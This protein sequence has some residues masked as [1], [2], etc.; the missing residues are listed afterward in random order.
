MLKGM[1]N[2]EDMILRVEDVTSADGFDKVQTYV[3]FDLKNK[4]RK[5]EIDESRDEPPVPLSDAEVRMV[6]TFT[7]KNAARHESYITNE[8]PDSIYERWKSAFL[9][10]HNM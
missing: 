9:A 10:F 7:L 1:Y 8:H 4:T 2:E 6:I 3:I 5:F